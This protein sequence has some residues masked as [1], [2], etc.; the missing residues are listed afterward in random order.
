MEEHYNSIEVYPYKHYQEEEAGS[1]TY[2]DH[3]I[4]TSGIEKQN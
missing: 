4:I 2:I 1:G 3:Q